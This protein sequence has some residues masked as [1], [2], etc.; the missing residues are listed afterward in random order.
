MAR[1]D[2]IARVRF[3]SPYPVDFTDDVIAA[4]AEEPALCKYVHLPVQ[5]GSDPVLARMRRGYDF[6][7]FRTLY[8]KLRA[9]PGIAITTDLLIG[10]C[11]ET[12]D[13]YAATLRAQEELRFDG[14]FTFA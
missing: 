13:E 7:T 3:T 14:A 5:S 12:D 11:D 6:A 8:R 9:V 10:F 1:V 4:I 2:G